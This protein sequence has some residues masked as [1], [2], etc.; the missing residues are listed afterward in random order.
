MRSLKLW[1]VVGGVVLVL[2]L[3]AVP[4]GASGS[5]SSKDPKVVITSPHPGRGGDYN[6]AK[7]A[8]IKATNFPPDTAVSFVEC[9]VRA[10]S[11]P[12]HCSDS[13]WALAEGTTNAKG[14]FTFSRKTGSGII[15]LGGSF[16]TD[17]DSDYCGN[18][19]S[20]SVPCY[21]TVQDMTSGDTGIS[22][23]ASYL[24]YCNHIQ[25]YRCFPKAPHK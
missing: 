18:G 4:S 23:S 20:D 9:A 6:Q 12:N 22:A 15:L 25:G 19:P 8:V 24:S 10:Q 3:S 13:N 17:P 1:T 5:S 14:E 11:D 16:F 7:Y 21:V 2:G